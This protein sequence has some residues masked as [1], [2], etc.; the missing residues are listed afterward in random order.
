MIT[1]VLE[2]SSRYS[3]LHP[4][5]AA[6]FKF[7]K[8]LPTDQPTG[9]HDLDGDNCFALVQFYTTKPL[10]QAAFEAHKKY[11]D[12]QFIQSGRETI[13]W[14]PL[15]SLPQ[16]TKPYIAEKDIA[17]FATPPHTVPVH[18]QAGQFTIFFPEDGHAPGVEYGGAT[19][20]RKVVIK[21]R[22]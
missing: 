18:L 17:F 1:D 13:L 22:A 3:S 16:V 19:E 10:A 8:Q 21:I 9:R 12:I 14:A 20:V 6:A 11:I 5:F 2:Q 7:L 4:H 15:S